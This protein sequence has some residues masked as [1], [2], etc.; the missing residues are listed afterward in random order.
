M[1]GKMNLAKHSLSSFKAHFMSQRVKKKIK[2]DIIKNT[3][4]HISA[5]QK[6]LFNYFKALIRFYRF[7]ACRNLLKIYFGYFFW[8]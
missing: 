2:L 3:D 1:F 6:M 4:A 7:F 5:K 8:L